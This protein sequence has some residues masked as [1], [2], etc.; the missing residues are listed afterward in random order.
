[1]K[2]ILYLHGLESTKAGP[3]AELFLNDYLIH[4][5]TLDYNDPD[6]YNILERKVK[7]VSPDIIIGSS[8]GGYMAM[9]LAT[10]TYHCNQLILLNPALSSPIDTINFPDK[11][12]FQK[13]FGKHY[14][15]TIRSVDVIVGEQDTV[16]YPDDTIEMFK[17]MKE[18]A[19]WLN[20]RIKTL[21]TGHRI[22]H[23]MFE[24][25]LQELGYLK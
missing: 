25:V 22:P 21:P 2:T 8:M 1:M 9:M 17:S 7:A 23:G 24:G 18:V 6:I 3:K 13:G 12:D 16:V 4:A 5:P 10:N 19:H 11:E 14:P 15:P 20:I